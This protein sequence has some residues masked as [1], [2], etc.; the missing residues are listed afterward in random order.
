M[1]EKT[2]VSELRQEV[3][4]LSAALNSVAQDVSAMRRIQSIAR[5][6]IGLGFLLHVVVLIAVLQHTQG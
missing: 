2:E 1:V 4:R 5:W 3:N 6:I